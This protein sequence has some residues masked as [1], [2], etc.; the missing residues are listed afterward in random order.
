MAGV[1]PETLAL[2]VKSLERREETEGQLERCPAEGPP[3]VLTGQ[4]QGQERAS[5]RPS[6]CAE[7]ADL[8]GQAEGG[9]GRWFGC[10]HMPGVSPLMPKRIV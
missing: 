6:L 4:V 7:A 3:H 8:L 10:G 5:R 2:K 1:S 9:P